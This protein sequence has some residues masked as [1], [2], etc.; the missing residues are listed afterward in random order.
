MGTDT[1]CS[2][3]IEA[4]LFDGTSSYVI[5]GMG[6]I[7]L[8]GFTLFMI[9]TLYQFLNVERPSVPVNVDDPFYSKP[10]H[11]MCGQRV[12]HR[13][14]LVRHGESEHNKKCKV[15]LKES[16]NEPGKVVIEDGTTE[17]IDIDSELTPIGHE[18]ARQ[19]AQYLDSI[20]F[21]PDEVIVSPMRRTQQT[22][23]PTLRLFNDLF[24]TNNITLSYS[25]EWMEINLWK[26]STVGYSRSNDKLAAKSS[27]ETFTGF[28]ARVGQLLDNIKEATK[29]LKKPKQTLVFTHSMVISEFLNAIVAKN[30]EN[31]SDQDWSDVYWQCTNGS[32]TCVD[33]TEN[34]AGR[35]ECHIQCMNFMRHLTLT[36]GVK[37]PFA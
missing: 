35:P 36:T 24:R 13:L 21:I 25:P 12:K 18:Q 1:E 27:R 37:S 5:A 17:D 14:V 30:R 4:A 28:V 32:I 10:L 20:G 8:G 34:D 26:D 16:E 9:N 6:G 2:D 22:A 15:I 11:G 33:F 23:F 29:T 7:L 3:Y 19:V 31:I